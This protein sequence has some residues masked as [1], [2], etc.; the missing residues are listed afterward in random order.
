M[1][2]IVELQRLSFTGEYCKLIVKQMKYS[3][4]L[5]PLLWFNVTKAQDA[6][7]YS[8]QRACEKGFVGFRENGLPLY[9]EAWNVINWDAVNKRL[10]EQAGLKR[11]FLHAASLQ[12]ALDGGR[13]PYVLTAPL[14]D[15]LA[16]ALDRLG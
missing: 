15:D 5:A 14:S 16:E 2:S 4:L 1:C 12:F 7:C 8:E 11:L 10:R 13:T 9:Y 3:L 6:L